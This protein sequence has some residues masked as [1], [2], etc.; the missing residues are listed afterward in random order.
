MD[1]MQPTF[2]ITIDK[3]NGVILDKLVLK[4]GIGMIGVYIKKHFKFG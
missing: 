1:N 4:N 2:M 3:N